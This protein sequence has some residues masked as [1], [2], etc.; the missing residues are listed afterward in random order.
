MKNIG[1]IS[2]Q[3]AAA[4]LKDGALVIDVRTIDEFKSGHLRNAINIPLDEVERTVPAR[5]TDKNHALLLHCRAGMRSGAAQSKLKN[6]GY[7]NVFNLGSYE[8]AESIVNKAG[9]SPD[10]AA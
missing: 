2:P 1:L 5:V 7:T 9:S 8:R 10:K 4:L 6:L 3:Q